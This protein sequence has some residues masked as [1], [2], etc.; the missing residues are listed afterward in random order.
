MP[1]SRRPAGQLRIALARRKD[2]RLLLPAGQPDGPAAPGPSGTQHD[3]EEQ[4][5]T[6]ERRQIVAV[7]GSH[8][9]PATKCKREAAAGSSCPPAPGALIVHALILI[10]TPE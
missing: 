1:D 6:I 2:R 4:Q 10:C 7:L 8:T 9:R 5:Q 3:D